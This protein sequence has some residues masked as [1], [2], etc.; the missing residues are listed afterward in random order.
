MLPVDQV[1]GAMIYDKKVKAGKVRFI[2]PTRIGA[3]TIRDDV[4][5]Q[6]VREAVESLR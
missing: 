1:V 5:E 3:V 2:L 6:V 4:P